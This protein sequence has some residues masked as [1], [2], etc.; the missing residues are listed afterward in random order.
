LAA[1]GKLISQFKGSTMLQ[2]APGDIISGNVAMTLKKPVQAREVG[3]CLIG[4]QWVTT[5][6]GTS[7]GV[8]DSRV[9][10]GGGMMGVGG[11]S[12]RG[13]LETTIPSDLSPTV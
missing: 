13:A 9:R 6:S 4:E 11:Q 10:P 5:Y 7:T 8:F 3:I 12:L 1:K 2:Y